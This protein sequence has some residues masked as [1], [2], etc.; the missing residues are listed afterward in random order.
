MTVTELT[1][2]F[3]ELESHIAEEKGDFAFFALFLPEDA[4]DYWDLMVAAPWAG[5]DTRSTVD[6]FVEQ[7]KSRL[8]AQVLT[9]LS[10][11][12]VI[13]PQHAAVQALNREIQIEHGRVE[14]RDRDF[15]GLPIKHAY[16]ITSKLAPAPA[17][18]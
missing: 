16:I 6:Y 3:T 14:I 18:A 5:D 17:A 1:E 4:P 2:K 15:F 10:R 13:D 7:I 9:S 11:I 8:G 12:V